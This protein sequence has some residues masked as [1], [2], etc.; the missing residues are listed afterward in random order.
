LTV[1]IC[2]IA[3][4]HWRG[5]SRH[6][7]YRKTYEYLIN[8]L[9]TLKPDIIY[10]G[11]D[12]VH[13][14]TQGISPELIKYLGQW[15]NDLSEICPVHMILGNHDGILHNKAR[16]D[17]ISPIV[18]LLDNPE[19]HLFK[20]SGVYPTGFPGFN[21]CV[22]SCFD[23]DGWENV[24]PVPGEINLAV[25]HGAVWGSKSDI[26]WE[27]EGE[28]TVDMFEGYDFTLLGDI[29]RMQFLSEDKRIA[30]PGS[31]IQQN[32]GE[33]Q[34]K[35]FL[36]WTIR[37]KDDFDVDF[38]VIPGTKPFVTLNWKGSV[39]ET[40]DSAK[41]YP[42]ESRFRIRSADPI[43]QVEI[44]QIQNSLKDL[45]DAT[46]V[47]W[48]WEDGDTP[49]EINTE[50]ASLLKNDLRDLGVHVSLLKEFWAKIP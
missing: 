2:H 29:H 50:S 26:D 12:I 49:N 8:E 28:V 27:V 5:S 17:A 33:S 40:I 13:S 25:Y 44:N 3:D 20:K 1:K 39:K 21:W 45:K 14:K 37:S 38:H 46:E 15:L 31:V 4:I 10:I 35:G 23:E 19:I 36:F 18:N 47:V 48:K 34:E 11:G 30:Y 32:Y 24:K 6:E 9:R 7:E 42:K 22:F 43:P 41:K 16:L